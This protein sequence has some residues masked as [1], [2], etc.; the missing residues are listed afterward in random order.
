MLIGIINKGSMPDSSST[1]HPSGAFLSD[2][3]FSFVWKNVLSA[4]Y[5]DWGPPDLSLVVCYILHLLIPLRCKT[6]YCK[7]CNSHYKN[8]VL[9][10]IMDLDILTIMSPYI[11]VPYLW[12]RPLCLVL[13]NLAWATVDHHGPSKHSSHYTASIVAQNILLQQRQ[14]YGVWNYW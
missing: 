13:L 14:N 10:V 7:K 8:L 1:N 9:D 3:L 4:I 5:V 6:W 2:I 11:D 12:I